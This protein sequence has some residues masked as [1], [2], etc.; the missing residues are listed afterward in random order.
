LEEYPE[1][2]SFEKEVL[3]KQLATLKMFAFPSEGYFID[4]GIPE[5]Y[6]K[7][8]NDFGKTYGRAPHE[9]GGLF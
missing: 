8:Q 7:A 1:V 2:F 5:D 6:Y 9:K 4:I 3:E